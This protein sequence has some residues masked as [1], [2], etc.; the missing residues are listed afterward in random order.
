MINN[1]DEKN[2]KKKATNLKGSES[3]QERY[4]SFRD[5]TYLYGSFF[6]AIAG[7]LSD[8]AI[9]FLTSKIT[10]EI[11]EHLDWLDN[12]KKKHGNLT[13][14]EYADLIGESV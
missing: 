1:D 8:K 12:E 13:M 14:E 10:P 6:L 7:E 3:Y 5:V 4:K 11:Q 2:I 9:D